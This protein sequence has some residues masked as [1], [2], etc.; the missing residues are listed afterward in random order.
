MLLRIY[1][2]AGALLIVG[3]VLYPVVRPLLEK[4]DP[5]SRWSLIVAGVGVTLLM[6]S[7][8]G[9]YYLRMRHELTARRILERYEHEREKERETHSRSGT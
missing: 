5:T 8:L 1:A 9:R 4:G 6:A 7:L 2:V 3:G